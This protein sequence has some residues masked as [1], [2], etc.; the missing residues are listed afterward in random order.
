MRHV[1]VDESSQNA[2]HYMVLGALILPGDLVREADDLISH[3]LATHGMPESELK[4]T[5]ISRGKLPCYQSVIDAYFTELVKQGAEFHA[6]IV[7][8]H[9]LDHHAY[10]DGDADLGFNKFLF[11]LL[12]YRVGFRFGMSE[13]IVVDLDARNSSRHPRELQ[14][15]LNRTFARKHKSPMHFPFSR[16][17]HRD[18]RGSRLIQVADL[19]TGAVA[20][21]K[22]EHDLK[23][24]ASP[25][26]SSIAQSIAQCVA[27][28][29]LGARSSPKW[30]TRLSTWNH[31]LRDRKGAR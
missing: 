9:G 10:N 6:V 4:W 20:W 21:H 29:R 17:A 22:N 1:F 11:S 7:D 2:H 31:A 8:C 3:I 23:P 28:D 18:S 15:C 19:L 5:K 30:E 24:G 16:V 14:E 12:N 25:A 13:K 26:K 27:V